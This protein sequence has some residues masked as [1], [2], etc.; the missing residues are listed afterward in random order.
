MVLIY[1]MPLAEMIQD[2]H[3]RLKSVTRGYGAMQYEFVGYRAGDLVRLDILVA[4]AR[5]DAL[6]QIMHRDQAYH[7]GKEIVARLAE[8]I[9]R[10]LFKITLQAAIGSRVIAREDI[11]ALAKN[12]TGKCYGG[13]V[14]R[15]RKLLEKQKEGKRRLKSVGQVEIPQEAFLSVMRPESEGKHR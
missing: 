10:H 15:K 6:S 12:V 9:P 2:F 5:V 4:S 1:E 7:R 3:D 14:T 13:D 11:P 8:T